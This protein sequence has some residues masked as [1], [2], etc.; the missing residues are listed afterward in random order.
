MLTKIYCPIHQNTQYIDL[1]YVEYVESAETKYCA[2]WVP[3]Q[4]KYTEVT[5]GMK[6]GNVIHVTMEKSK[7]ETLMKIEVVE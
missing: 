7:L 5:F 6:S 1:A 4:G 2:N 3:N